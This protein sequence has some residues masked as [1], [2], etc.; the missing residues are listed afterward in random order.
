MFE[1]GNKTAYAHNSAFVPNGPK[2]ILLYGDPGLTGSPDTEDD[3]ALTSA[4]IPAWDEA[5]ERQDPIYV[6]DHTAGGCNTGDDTCTEIQVTEAGTYRINYGL[7][8]SEGSV[9]ASRYQAVSYVQNNTDGSTDNWNADEGVSCFDSSY[10]RQTDNHNAIG[11]TGECLIELEADGKVR[12]GLSK[13]GNLAG[14]G[15]MTFANDQ[16]WFS[17]EKVENPTVSLRKTGA[18]LTVNTTPDDMTFVDADIVTYDS[19]TFDFDGSSANAEI[20][21]KEDGFYKATYSSLYNAPTGRTTILGN[22]YTNSSG[23]MQEDIYGGSQGYN[24]NNAGIDYNGLS[25]STILELS[26][27]DLV[28][29]VSITELST[30]TAIKYHIDLEYIGTSANILRLHDSTGGVDLDVVSDVVIDWDSID[31]EGSHFATAA[32]AI[33][34]TTHGPFTF[35]ADGDSDED[36]WIFVSDNGADGLNPS[37]TDRAWSHDTNDSPSTD[38]GPTSGQGG[39][40]DGYVYTEASSPT[41]AGDTFHMTFDTILDASSSTGSDWVVEFYW[42]QR[43]NDNEATLNL[44]TNENGAGWVTRGTF[45]GSPEDV[46]SGDPQQWNF[47]SV[48]LSSVI[49][50]SS[51]EVR[52]FVTISAVGTVWHEDFALDTITFK[53]FD[54]GIPDTSEIQVTIDGVYH[55]SYGLESR[56]DAD[57]NERFGQQTRLEINDGDGYDDAIGCFA[58]GW[59]RGDSPHLNATASC[60]LQLEGGDRIR[61]VSLQKGDP[62]VGANQITAADATYITIHSLNISNPPLLES[63][64]FSAVA[65]SFV[66]TPLPES[67]PLSATVTAIKDAAVVLTEDFP[68]DDGL[69]S[70]T[71]IGAAGVE[72]NVGFEEF[73]EFSDA[74]VPVLILPIKLTETLSFSAVATSDFAGTISFVESL[75]FTDNVSAEPF[76][77]SNPDF[78]IQQGTFTTGLSPDTDMA[79]LD[80]DQCAASSECFIMQIGTRHTSSGDTVGTNSQGSDDWT[81]HFSDVGGLD[82][83]VNYITLSRFG[84]DTAQHRIAW[85]II[86]YI[87]PDSGPN[88]MKVLA[89]STCN[90]ATSA[91]S[92]TGSSP[93][94]AALDDDDVAVIITGVSGDAT[95]TADYDSVLVTSEWK[96]ASSVPVFNRTATGSAELSV[97]Y[98]VVEFTGSS[99]NLQR[100]EH[101]GSDAPFPTQTE[102]MTD[103]GDL[104]RAFILQDQQR[105]A[106]GGGA[107]GPCET[108]V[109]HLSET[110]EV[111]FTHEYG[112]TACTYD[113]DMEHIVWILSN[114][115]TQT[116]KK[117]I[118]E[119]QQPLDQTNTSGSND[120]DEENWQR[121]INSLTYGTD[122]TAIFGFTANADDVDNT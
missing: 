77:P 59:T 37:D 109:V 43:G 38:V 120:P 85:Q 42:N 107:D 51:T 41:V 117:M 71:K 32:N 116:G 62:V 100:I 26:K 92:C 22:I 27:N 64:S 112:G 105:N 14:S 44:Q 70:V 118:V 34:D 108:G 50:D 68:L 53:G 9:T 72:Y 40:P 79:D 122:E 5:S 67:F 82:S 61:L 18:S 10:R 47:E 7:S 11:W 56:L 88:E 46:I 75:T 35:D 74:P 65:T 66:T 19:S 103:V 16:N 45:G 91:D 106:D 21:V 39:D 94:I 33:P 8:I 98:A 102:S 54:G 95:G 81:F 20:Q 48:D 55:I 104:S 110:D 96:G 12:I 3:M 52:F 36:A 23:T 4:V 1:F 84:G 76:V 97:S 24:R 114:T 69:I 17:M 99:W 49:S 57:A 83:D 89:N 90:F 6:H 115:N 78:K 63:I 28:K 25:G 30:V 87:G 13:V 113:S 73:L 121:S 60:I 2:I 80:Y 93:S 15:S 119:H 86:E 101:T 111:S 29:F 31:E 58:D